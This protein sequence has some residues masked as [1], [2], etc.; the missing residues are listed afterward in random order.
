MSTY[1][2]DTG[3]GYHGHYEQTNHESHESVSL[4]QQLGLFPHA[5]N[6]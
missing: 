3:T 1:K 6:V 2:V 5:K 4:T